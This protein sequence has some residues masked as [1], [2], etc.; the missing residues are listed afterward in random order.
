M[1]TNTV[2]VIV[3][4]QDSTTKTYII[5]LTRAAALSD[6]ADLGSLTISSGTLS[7]QFSSSVTAYTASVD[8]SVTQVTVTPTASDSSA[9]I[10]VNDNTVTSGIGYIVT[11]LTVDTN[12]VTVIVTAQDSTTKTY[13]ITLTRAA[14]LS[15]NADLG[16]LTISSGTLSPQFSSSVT[17]YTAS[18][19]NSVTQ[20]TVTPTASD[21]LATIAVNDNTV[22]SGIGYIVTGLTVDTNTVTVIVTAQ[23]STT[24]TYIITLTRAAALSD[25]ADLG[26]LTISSG[27]LSPQFSSSVTAYTASVDNSV[28]Q[29]TVTPTASDSLATIAV[30]DNTVTSGIG[31][32][33]TGLTVDTNTVTVIV[34]AQDSTTKTYIITLTRAAALSDNAD[35]GSLTISS[36]TL[37]PQF[38]SSVTAYTASVDNSVTQVTVTPTASDSL[39]TIAV[40]DNTVTSGI[41]YILTGLTVDTNTVT[42]IVT[43]QDSTTKTYIITLTRAAALSDNADLGSLTISS[44]TLS[45]QFSSSVTAYTA[46]VDNS[47]TQVT[48]TP[49]ASDSLAT[50]AVNDNTVTSGIGYI[51]TGLTVDTNTVTVIV[52]AQDST[53]KTYIITLTRAAALSDNADL[54]SLTISSG[55][56]SPQFSSSVTAYTASVDNSVTQVTVTPTASDSSATIAVNDNTVTSGIGYILTGLTVDTNTVTVIVTAQDS[57]TKTYIITLT[58]AAALSDNADLG[59]LTISSGTLSPQFSSSVTAYTASVDNSVTQVTVTPTA[60][61]SSATIAVNDNTVTS[62]IGYILTGLTVDTNT[63]T[64]IVTAQDSTT[65]T[66]IITLTRAAALSDNADLGSLTISS[67]TLSPQFSSSVTAYTASVDNSVTQVT[68]TPTA[69]DSSAT[70][71]VNDNTVTSGIGYILTGLTVDTNTVTVIV[72]AQDSTTKTYIITLTRAAALSDNADL[73]SLTIS[74]GTLS[75]QFSSSVTAYTASVDNSVTQVTVTP[76]A[77]DSLATIAVNDNTVTSGIGYILTGLTVDTNTVT[78]IVTAQDSTTKTYII[79]LTRAAALSDNADLGSL[80]ISSGTLSPQFSSSVTAYT[81]SV[82]NSVTQVTVTPTASDSLATI[83]V[84]D[85]TVTSGI[86]YILTG[87][88]V[89][90]NTVTVIVTAQDST[91]KTYIIT[92]TRAAALSDNADLGSLTI[93][94]GTL[95]PQF[96]SSVTAYTASVD[97]SVTQVTVTPTASDSSATIAVN[98]NTVTS[99]IGYILTGLTVDTNT[100]TVIVT[101]QDSTTKT[102]IITLTRAAAL[103]D[104]ADLG[105]LTISSGT[106]SPQFSSSVTAYTASVDNSVTQ[107]TVT[108]T[109]SDSSAT[110]AVN[111]NTVTSGIGYILTGLTVDTNTVTVIVTAQDS[112]TKTYIITLTRAAALSDN[113]DLG[114][115]TI[116]SGTLSPQFSSSVTA[117]TASVDNSVTQVTVTP[118]ASDS[119]A[120]IAVNDNTVTS[121]IGYILTGLTVDTNTVTVIV[122]AQDSTTKT[123]IITLTRA[124]ALSDNADLGSLTISSGTLS[125]QFSSSVTAYTA[126][127]DNSVTQVTVTPTASDSSATIAVNDNTVTSGIGY[128]LTGLTVDTNTVTV[129]VTAQDSTT[130]TYIITLTRAAALSDNADLGSLTISS[131]TLS[132]Q[133]SS[134]VTAYTASVDNSVTQV[135]VTPTASDSSATIAVN[136]NTVTSGIGYILTGLTVDTNTVTVIVTAQDSTTKTY[137]ITLTRAAALSDNAD[138]GSLTISSGTLSP[139]FSSSV[140]AYTASVDNS[141]TQVTVTPTASDSSATITVNDNTV[142]SGIGYILT[143]LTVD[144]NTVTVIV[145]A[146]DSTTKTYI[147]TLTRAAALSDNAD[148]GSLTISSGTL[149]PQFSSSVTAYTASVDNSVTQVTV[150]PTASDS[151]ATIAVND[152]TVTSGNG[153]I[154]TGL[155]VDTNTVTVIVTAQD[156]TTKTY[157]ITLTRAAALSDNADLGSLTISSGTLS[158]QFSSSVTAYTASV[159]NSVTQV[160]VTPTASDSSATI[161]VNDNTVTSGIGYILTGLTVDTN[162]V[163]VIVTAQDS[164]TKTYIITL[165]RAAALSDNADLGSL[166]ISSGTLSP[167]FS[168][169]VTAYTASV[170]NSVT[171]VTVTPT[172]SDSSA[173]IAVNDNTVTSGIGYI[174]TGLTVDTNTVTVIVTAQDSTTKTYIITLTRAAALSDNADLGSL[175]ISSGT[176]S[177][178]FS[179]SVTAYTASVD[180]SVTQVTVTP[181]ASD[182]SATITVNDNTVTSGTG[183]ILTGLTVGTNTVTVIVT[184]QD[185]TTKTYIITLT[186]AAALSDNADLGSLTISSGT[187]SPQFSSSVTAY[188]ASVDNSVTQVTVTPTASD[189]S[190]TIA[191]ND[192]TVTSGNGYILTGLTVDTNTVTVI[193]TAQDS[194]TKTYIITLTRAAA[195]SDNADLGSLTISSGTLSPQF[196]SSV[197]AYTASVDNSVTQVTVTPTASDSSATIAVNGNTVTSGTGYIL[198]GLTAGTTTVTVIVTAQDS[199]T[200]TYIITLTRAAAL[201]DNADLGSLTISS[202]TLSPQFSSSVT[203]Y[204]ASVDNSVTQVTVTPTASDSSATITVNGNTVTSGTGYILT[205]LTAGTTTVTVIVTAQDS[206]TK[207]YIITLT[208]AAALSDNADLG[209][210]TISSGTLSPQFS[211]SVT[212]YTAS[213]DNSVTQVTVTPTASDSSATIAVNDNTVTSGTG[214]ILTGLTVDTNT[215][216]VI[217]TA[218]DS[219]T[220]TY[221]ITLTRAAALSDNADLGS[222]TISSGTLSPQFSSSVTAYTAS[223]DNSVTQVTV[224]PTASDSSATIANTVT[225]GTGYSHRPDCGHQHRHGNS[226]CPGLYDQDLHHYPYTCCCPL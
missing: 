45:P 190:A 92:L 4:A 6:N 29:V 32:I 73:G 63:V 85:N 214:Y 199:T 147:I 221:I 33:V 183:Y 37:S 159:D 164:T 108:P 5:T 175:T 1:D 11:G 13:I 10:A 117:Y 197:T 56:L 213:V 8:N 142:T 179:S 123:Y 16:S 226:Y 109:A 54:G 25:N 101:A 48:V 3:T 119:S 76:T 208:R 186:R 61:D 111:D 41:G 203:A 173:T 42:V 102:Y 189:S 215:V 212:A 96:S 55:T 60:S 38:S 193:V 24:K 49:T 64:V 78:V 188:T 18:V 207:T 220:K 44:G 224:T 43:A 181:T 7:P 126:S 133:F 114:S 198:T 98:D 127:V 20:V 97:N 143:G 80:T 184:A 156:S 157:I 36:G 219:T 81:A 144:T 153:Y 178:Q 210:L 27:T 65:K 113:A 121:G 222:L 149:S 99:G 50:I 201:S 118:T 23:D 106:L 103:S 216:T 100:V 53:T 202:G 137:I 82:D 139:Q 88:T 87:L 116:S 163:T 218:Q 171:Q 154:L 70:I 130:K 90:T 194:T 93:S 145:T 19:D 17:A 83:A 195:L 122:T 155:T 172:A 160:T 217:V 86:G 12:T 225:S 21:S 129:I 209:S 110:I 35:L 46:S 176:L 105:S 148:L 132:P 9:T 187:L 72:T 165:T 167:Q 28:T 204:T 79:T 150:T 182:S 174:L 169:S 152:N 151:S 124:A 120:T 77:S 162:T 47:V 134:S 69:S 39:A 112:T 180:N 158:P 30:N 14:A 34:T 138:L 51:V 22:T 75:P 128:I 91:T 166:T 192:N 161:A 115:L 131:G 2:T 170:D 84:N 146:Q 136:D 71:A 141:V 205:G 125:P 135:T 206:T 89:D 191:V 94:S 15:D 223:V 62:G 177:P 31:Y 57:T 168:S 40:N 185:S 107:V 211:S 58:R 140:T 196:S 67:G 104:N 200:K 26:S 68:V 66:Y 59:S 52:T 95:S 74:S